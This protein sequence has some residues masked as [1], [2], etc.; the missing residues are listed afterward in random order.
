MSMTNA[1]RWSPADVG[2]REASERLGAEEDTPQCPGDSREDLRPVI[3]ET[4]YRPKGG[5]EPNKLRPPR[6]RSAIEAPE[7]TGDIPPG[8]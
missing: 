6:W 1:E 2:L 4:G 5:L 3:V 8:S 7:K